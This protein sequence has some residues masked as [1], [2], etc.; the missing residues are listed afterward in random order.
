MAACG[1]F[2][3]LLM[4]KMATRNCYFHSLTSP[5][6]SNAFHIYGEQHVH[7]LLVENYGLN[8]KHSFLIMAVIYR[9]LRLGFK[10]FKWFHERTETACT[11]F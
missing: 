5:L 7:F 3:M 6:L 8:T 4:P 9:V 1:I 10:V 11:L 2:L